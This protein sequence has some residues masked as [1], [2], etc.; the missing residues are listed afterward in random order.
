MLATLLPRPGLADDPERL[1]ALDAER[2]AVDRLDD[3]V[4]GLEVDLEVLDLEQRLAHW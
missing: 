1:A 4:V 2:D 3:A